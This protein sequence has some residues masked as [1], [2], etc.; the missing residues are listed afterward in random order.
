MSSPSSPAKSPSKNSAE[1]PLLIDDPHPH[2]PSS[3]TRTPHVPFPTAS[4]TSPDS[5]L[6]SHETSPLN[7]NGP[8]GIDNDSPVKTQLE[9]SK[10]T[11]TDSHSSLLNTGTV[12]DSLLKTQHQ[13]DNFWHKG[14]FPTAE[15]ELFATSAAGASLNMSSSFEFESMF[16]FT[17]ETAPADLF[18]LPPSPQNSFRKSPERT[19]TSTVEPAEQPEVSPN[20][21][22]S[23]D[24]A[25]LRAMRP[26]LQTKYENAVA[27]ILGGSSSPQKSLQTSP[28]KTFRFPPGVDPDPRLLSQL[29]SPSPYLESKLKPLGHSEIP[30]P[31]RSPER[32]PSVLRVP[33]QSPSSEPLPSVRRTPALVDPAANDA[34]TSFSMGD[35]MIDTLFGIG[36]KGP[37]KLRGY[38][39]NKKDSFNDSHELMI[40]PSHGGSLQ[41]AHAVPSPLGSSG[42]PTM[43]KDGTLMG[44]DNSSSPGEFV[45]PLMH[46][47]EM[48]THER[49]WLLETQLFKAL[50]NQ[51][52]SFARTV[53]SSTGSPTKRT[54]PRISSSWISGSENTT[55]NPRLGLGTPSLF[56]LPPPLLPSQ[57]EM[58]YEGDLDGLQYARDLSTSKLIP[59]PLY[60]YPQPAEVPVRYYPRPQYPQL[61]LSE[62]PNPYDPAPEEAEYAMW[63]CM[64][65]DITGCKRPVSVA[66][67]GCFQC[68]VSSEYYC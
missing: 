1:F 52:P 11:S 38:F 59:A 48:P 13:D 14:I 9:A 6:Y 58:A 40:P 2:P 20:S 45:I 63:L 33:T 56:E 44:Q 27:Q 39:L 15:E 64:W 65:S 55:L 61:P 12:S 22:R 34:P 41:G 53:V 66:R 19:N 23:L 4:P 37:P 5:A 26:S 16:D 62:Q 18:G 17:E 29:R 68:T 67:T 35:D 36:P 8:N 30:K 7:T 3:T 24:E 31:G 46:K 28:Q 21:S 32:V 60:P 50:H 51:V 57:L 43:N 54:T 10:G 42:L 47:N 49:K 25:F